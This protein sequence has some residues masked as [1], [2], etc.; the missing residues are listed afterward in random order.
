MYSSSFR[1]GALEVF[2]TAI[3][4]QLCC[5]FVADRP[6]SEAAEYDEFRN[7]HRGSLPDT[8]D[9]DE[10]RKIFAANR[11]EVAAHNA[12]KLSWTMTLNHFADYSPSELQAH[13]GY[14]RVGGRWA[15]NQSAQRSFLQTKAHAE[16]HASPNQIANL[17]VSS[18]AETIDWRG[19]MNFS[20]F[21]HDQGACGSCWAHAAV[22]AI[23]AYAELVTGR[24]MKLATQQII[25]CTLNPRHC[26]GSGGCEGAT[27]EMAFEHAREFGLAEA[28]EYGGQGGKCPEK[29]PAT[30]QLQSFVRL[31]ENRALYLMQALSEKGPV[32][33]S[34]A[35][36]KLFLYKGGVFSGCDRDTVVDHAV[37]GVGYGVDDTSQK[38]YWLIKNS[39]GDHW[40]ENGYMKMERFNDD[41]A[42]CGTDNKPKEGVYCDDAPA[43]IRVC[44]MCGVTSDSTYPVI[45]QSNNLRQA[46]LAEIRNRL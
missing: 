17:D 25:D 34:I 30:V 2:V 40:G 45:M 1:I 19:K 26:G 10:R 15:Q 5:L 27:S 42:Y 46:H 21:V 44:G 8:G 29:S 37:L 43:T 35:A 12:R 13:L 41:N 4:S 28:S 16:P 14:K 31:P 11:D 32:V 36:N 6:E 24:R 20:N 9:Y 7:I 33:V 3:I 39:W 18:F 22:A 38:P 23:E